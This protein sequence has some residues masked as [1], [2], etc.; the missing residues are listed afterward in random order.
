MERRGFAGAMSAAWIAFARNGDPN[1]K[2]LP[3]WPKYTVK[4]RATMLLDD[5][6]KVVNDPFGERDV[7]AGV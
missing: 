3:R 5:R 1:T 7:W 6:P 2:A 4:E